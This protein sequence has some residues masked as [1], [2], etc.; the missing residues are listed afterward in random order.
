MAKH[1]PAACICT[2]TTTE[3]TEGLGV[4]ESKLLFCYSLTCNGL[5]S[6]SCPFKMAVEKECPKIL[7]SMPGIHTC[8]GNIDMHASHGIDITANLT[9]YT[10]HILTAWNTGMLSTCRSPMTKEHI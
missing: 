1:N 5:G 10:L 4:L 9:L 6:L 3:G 2:Y 8:K 7:I